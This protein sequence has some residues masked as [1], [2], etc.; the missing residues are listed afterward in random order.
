MSDSSLEELARAAGLSVQWTDAFGNARRISDDALHGLLEAMGWPSQDE[1]N[2][3]VSLQRISE[4]DHVPPSLITVDV[5]GAFEIP[6][7][8]QGT[9][10]LTALDEQG[11]SHRLAPLGAGHYRPPSHHGYYLLA[12]HSRSLILAVAPLRCFGVDDGLGTHKQR[13]W[14]LSAQVYSLRHPNDGG[15]GD[16]RAAAEL[17]ETIGHAGGDALA[18][19]PLHA[20]SPIAGHYSPYSPSHRG[21]LNWLHADPAQV[22]GTSA[23]NDAIQRS[24][25][26]STW[27]HAQQGQRVDW[28]VAYALRR[29]VFRALHE[30][31]AHASQ[32]LHDDLK[33]FIDMRGDALQHYAWL[34]A[35]Q[36]LAVLAG[37]AMSWKA[38]QD[39]WN[40]ETSA[41]AFAQHRPGEVD[42][43]IFLQW[44][45][46]RCWENTQQRARDA[47]QHIGLIWD[48]AV[49]FVAGGGEAWA[50]R[51]HIL[52]GLELG[53]P[54]DAFNPD[55]QSWGITS[56]SP[57]GLKASGFRP[58]IELLRANMARGGGI[59]IDHILGFKH[60]WALP[61]GEPST[62]GGYIQQPLLDLL[63]LT[64]LESWRHRCIVIGEDLG[65]VPAGLREMLASRGVLGIDV[66][67]FTRDG[68]GDFLAP[69][70]WRKHAV[71]T[72]TTHD[73]P[74]LAAWREGL[75]IAQLA[76][77]HG[78][79][80][81]EVRRRMRVRE[82]EVACL[83][84]VIATTAP[85][86]RRRPKSSF[87][88][89]CEALKTDDVS[90][91]RV[92]KLDSSLLKA[93][94]VH[95][96]SPRAGLRRN[97]D[98]V[99]QAI[100]QT[101]STYAAYLAQTPS[102]LL[103]LPLED[104]LNLETQ[105]NLPGTVDS[106]PNWQHRLPHDTLDQLQPLLQSIGTS[107]EEASPA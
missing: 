39:D 101:C 98:E 19:S 58:F 56:Y 100:P 40:N 83:H 91:G 89:S 48:L 43:E 42:L 78:W 14:G 74:P 21:F 11:R 50:W 105:P 33:H 22:L 16:S 53:A 20:M 57:W 47:G 55:G 29:N 36:S 88:T 1:A 65:T 34:A 18:L 99:D 76:K 23:L 60:V 12:T 13:A 80:E 44:L 4:R 10:P 82:D 94:H 67:L 2:R 5:G 75:D 79:G 30:Q 90:C 61:E 92:S 15:L 85:S 27:Q 107:I 81:E 104:A 9:A 59:R 49:G 45:A 25:L 62:E 32:P 64:A 72:T 66:L 96:L 68:H 103:I 38:W 86:F 77:V 87:N 3:K 70:S 17:A 51:D 73:M 46:T 102:L 52:Q 69:G 26:A 54:P 6:L 37:E 41:F 95:V 63:R 31:F 84:R 93:E 35:R 7:D 28:P 71:A 8:T 24:G 106:H 97:D